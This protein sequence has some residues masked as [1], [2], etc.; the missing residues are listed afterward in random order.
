ME[1]KKTN[2]YQTHVDLGANMVEFGGFLMPLYYTTIADEHQAVRNH[3][4]MFDVSHMGE[5]KITGPDAL[6]FVNNLLTSKIKPGSKMIYGLLCTE[7]GY[8]I[9][10]LMVYPHSSIDLLLVVNASNK[11]KD[12]EWILS[13]SKDYDVTIMDLSNSIGEI[14]LQGPESEN[15][16]RKLMDAYPNHSQ[17]YFTSKYQGHDLIISRSGYTGEDGFEI[18]GDQELIQLLWNEFLKLDVKP[19]GLGCRDTLRFE[20]AMPLY[21]HEINDDINPIEAGLSFAVDFTKDQFI[22]KSALYEYSLNPKRKLVGIQ[23]LERNVARANYPVLKDDLEIG[24]ITTGYLSPTV[25]LP[26]AMALIDLNYAKLGEE[27]FILIRNKKVPA[28]IRNRKFY[29]KKNKI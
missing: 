18:Y 11:D 19:C 28:L 4:G 22:G 3:S 23:L 29:Q 10:D 7:K 26:I 24:F 2:L 14:A 6:R 5:I 21:G 27:V 16:L 15:I 1:L 20:A 12:F 8:V 17:D 13:Q 25:Q 9:D